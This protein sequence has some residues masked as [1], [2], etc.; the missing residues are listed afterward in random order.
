[1]ESLPRSGGCGC[2]ALGRGVHFVNETHRFV[3]SPAR[4]SLPPVPPFGPAA[5]ARELSSRDDGERGGK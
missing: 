4:L 1:M 3:A 5:A 2:A